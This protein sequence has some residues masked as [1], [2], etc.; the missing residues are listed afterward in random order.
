MFTFYFSNAISFVHY[1][2]LGGSVLILE[3]GAI[4]YFFKDHSNKD[5]IYMIVIFIFYAYTFYQLKLYSNSNLLF[6]FKQGSL[7]LELY[8]ESFLIYIVQISES[9]LASDKSPHLKEFLLL[10]EW[11]T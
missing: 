3:V 9:L 4:Q 2:L 10:L 6:K 1:V 11:H 7:K 5:G 8:N